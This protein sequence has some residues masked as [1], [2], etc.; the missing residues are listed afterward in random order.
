MSKSCWGQKNGRVVA[1]RGE[2]APIAVIGF[3]KRLPL[4]IISEGAVTL[5]LESVWW[6]YLDL[7]QGPNDYESFALTN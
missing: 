5:F 4:R 3:A 7:N 1:L 2:V 6:R